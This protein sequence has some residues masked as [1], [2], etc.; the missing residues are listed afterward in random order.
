MRV[1]L[2]L[3]SLFFAHF[4]GRAGA[5]LHRQK[6]PYT[7]ALTWFLRTAVALWGIVWTRGFDVLSIVALVLAAASFAA[8]VYAETRPRQTEEAHLFPKG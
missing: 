3:L 6:Q 5:R 2:L 7:R 1:A 4:L 8:G